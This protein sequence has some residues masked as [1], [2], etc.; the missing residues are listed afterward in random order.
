V[1]SYE[2]ERVGEEHGFSGLLARLKNV[3][4][5]DRGTLYDLEESYVLKIVDGLT[6]TTNHYS[7]GIFLLSIGNQFTNP[8][9]PQCH[10][11]ALDKSHK[12]N[13]D[14]TNQFYLLFL[15]DLHWAE[16]MSMEQG[17]KG[18]DLLRVVDSL[19]EF[20]CHYLESAHLQKFEND[21]L[22]GANDE[23]IKGFF[24]KGLQEF[25]KHKDHFSVEVKQVARFL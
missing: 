24:R 9:F 6:H 12:A 22:Y 18:Q 23:L 13:Q 1:K 20:H 25:L 16:S 8:V 2:T 11:I 4:I 10:L 14:K 17:L 3:K 7:E 15:E 19:A 5:E 21:I